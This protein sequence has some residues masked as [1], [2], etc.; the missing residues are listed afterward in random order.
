VIDDPMIGLLDDEVRRNL[1]THSAVIPADLI[2]R[3][4]QDDG[5][6]GK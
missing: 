4:A 2:L 6:R 1:K 5:P 3:Q